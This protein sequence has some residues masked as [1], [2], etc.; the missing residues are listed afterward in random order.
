MATIYVCKALKPY[1]LKKKR[2]RELETHNVF[3]L[4]I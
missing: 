2:M 3:S 1:L 4:V